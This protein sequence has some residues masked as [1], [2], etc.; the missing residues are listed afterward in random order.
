SAAAARPTTTG[1]PP[2]QRERNGSF[3]GSPCTKRGVSPDQRGADQG[4]ARTKVWKRFPVGRDHHTRP[5]RAGMAE[6]VRKCAAALLRRTRTARADLLLQPAAGLRL[7]AGL[8]STVH[9]KPVHQRLDPL[10]G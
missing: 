4:E 7:D 2:R 6:L 10:L 1:C 5:Q 3:M 8:E 9:T